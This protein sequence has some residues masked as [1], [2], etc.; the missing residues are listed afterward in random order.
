MSDWRN[1][2]DSENKFADLNAPFEAVFVGAEF[3]QS[4]YGECL[5]LRF[6]SENAGA[7]VIQTKSRR[8]KNLFKNIPENTRVR[9]LRNG[10]GFETHYEVEVLN[11]H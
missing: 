1:K 9:V 6:M 3:I 8:L 4:K 5:E 7:K 2:V 11:G 10:T